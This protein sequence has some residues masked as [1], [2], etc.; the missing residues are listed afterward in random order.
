MR[1]HTR[2][3]NQICALC[4]RWD[5]EPK[6]SAKPGLH[7]YVEYETHPRARCL[8]GGGYQYGNNSC[9]KFE[10]SIEADRYNV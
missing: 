3:N 4:K 2:A 10:I 9:G 8:V 1:T 6:L 7:G 5:G